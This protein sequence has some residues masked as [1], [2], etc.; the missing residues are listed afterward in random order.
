MGGKW[1]ASTGEW[2]VFSEYRHIKRE[3]VSVDPPTFEY[4]NAGIVWRGQQEYY[5][6]I[7]VTPDTRSTWTFHKL[8]EDGFQGWAAIEA[9]QRLSGK[10]TQ[11]DFLDGYYPG[12]AVI[13]KPIGAAFKEFCEALI[14]EIYQDEPAFEKQKPGPK[15]HGLY[16]ECF[17]KECNGQS[18]DVV[19]AHYCKQT[20]IENPTR[21]DRRNYNEAMRRRNQKRRKQTI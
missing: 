8:T 10:E 6:G 18:R 12:P 17:E 13:R 19:F 2:L 21:Q 16:D 7:D 9:Y 3:L 11:L 14:R 4:H 1:K 20:G 5:K 15:P